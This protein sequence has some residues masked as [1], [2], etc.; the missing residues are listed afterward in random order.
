MASDPGSL[1]QPVHDVSMRYDVSVPMRDGVALS[2][3]IYLPA[4]DRPLPVVLIRTPYNNNNEAIV[5]DCMYF[6]TRG[7]AVAT[8]D[9]RGRWDSDGDWYPFVHEAEDGFDTMEWIGRQP[10]CNGRIGTAGGSYVAMVQ[11]Q[12]APLRSRFL[13]AMVPRVGYSDFYHNW[14]YTGGAFQLAFNLRWCAIQMSTRTNQ[15]QYLW[16]PQ[17]NH[18]NTL[19]W[20]LPLQTMDAEAGRDSQVWKDWIAHPDYDDYWRRMRPVE[21]EYA[22]VDVPAYGIGGWYDVFL[23]ST[24]N[25]FMGVK[26]RRACTGQ[27]EP[28]DHHRPVDSRLR[29]HGTA[30]PNRRRRTRT[31]G[32]RRPDGRARPVVR[33]LAERRGHRHRRRAAGSRVRDGRQPLA[34][35]GRLADSGHQVRALLPAQ[36]GAAPTPCSGTGFWTWRRRRWSRPT[37]TSTIRKIP[38]RPW[39]AARAAPRT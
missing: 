9:V 17:A 10:W 36:P 28:E 38:C 12:A 34:A 26:T 15:V 2:T 32:A 11:W 18:L 30:H 13:K 23:Q 5:H 3:D 4:I 21:A 20:H 39:A 33:L 31:W 35:G 37:A 19:H 7:Y 29:R 27:A 22:E 16:L 8:Q 14:V 24:L 25:N 1:S 6:A